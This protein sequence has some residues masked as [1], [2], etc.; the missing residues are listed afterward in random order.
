MDE[1]LTKTQMDGDGD[2]HIVVSFLFNY[3]F[4]H[5]ADIVTVELKLNRGRK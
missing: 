1:E 4:H 2:L 5:G 3:E